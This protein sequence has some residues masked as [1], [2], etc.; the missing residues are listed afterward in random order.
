M[1]AEQAGVDGMGYPWDGDWCDEDASDYDEEYL[2]SHREDVLF[3]LEDGGRGARPRRP[4]AAELAPLAW[5]HNYWWH[6]RDRIVLLYMHMLD[7]PPDGSFLWEARVCEQVCRLWSD[8]R[9]SPRTSISYVRQGR[10]EGA[11]PAST[12]AEAEAMCEAGMR[13]VWSYSALPGGETSGGE[14]IQGATFLVGRAVTVRRRLMT[15]QC[16][17]D[18]AAPGWRMLSSLPSCPNPHM[19]FP[20]SSSLR[21]IVSRG[22]EQPLKPLLPRTACKCGQRIGEGRAEDPRPLRVSSTRSLLEADEADDPERVEELRPA[23]RACI[24]CLRDAWDLFG[25]CCPDLV[26]V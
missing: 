23:P 8:G 20:M 2:P 7:N 17:E 14:E 24:L 25:I 13:V 18:E 5:P 3:D 4:T 11:R 16:F 15:H 19:R 1:V 9:D 21:E 12:R 26:V 6:D 10:L 22:G